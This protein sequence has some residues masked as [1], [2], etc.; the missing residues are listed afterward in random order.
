[1]RQDGLR[2]A[3]ESEDVDVEDALV[4]LDGAFLGGPRRADAGMFTSTSIRPNRWITC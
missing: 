1:V 3:D 2:H 4:L